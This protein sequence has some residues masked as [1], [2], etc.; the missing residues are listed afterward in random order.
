MNVEAENV[1]RDFKL[2][3][4]VLYLMLYAKM[5]FI[6]SSLRI[7]EKMIEKGGNIIVLDITY[8]WKENNGIKLWTLYNQH[9][10]FF[11]FGI[12]TIIICAD[13]LIILRLLLGIWFFSKVKPGHC[14]LSNW[15]INPTT[16]IACCYL[17]I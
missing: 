15:F 3:V 11:S 14:L 12:M 4:M 17:N 6:K 16:W 10:I 5:V 9:S 2:R 7:L 13:I 1:Y 8:I